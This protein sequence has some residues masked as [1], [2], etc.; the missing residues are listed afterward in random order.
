MFFFGKSN[1]V[2]AITLGMF[3]FFKSSENRAM[4]AYFLALRSNFQTFPKMEVS[5]PQSARHFV[6]L[7]S[8]GVTVTNFDSG[9]IVITLGLSIV[10]VMLTKGLTCL[11]ALA[12]T[13]F[14]HQGHHCCLYHWH[15]LPV[16]S[17]LV[18]VEMCLKSL[19]QCD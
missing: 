2:A 6:F 12:S 3:F 7:H 11:M 17:H 1:A 15:N 16:M 10:L 5:A 19:L 4:T 18:L 8:I 9:K 14:L 13:F